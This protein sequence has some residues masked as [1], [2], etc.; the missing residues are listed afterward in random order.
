[1]AA[2]HAGAAPSTTQWLQLLRAHDEGM[3]EIVR[4]LRA[5]YKALT[6]VDMGAIDLTSDTTTL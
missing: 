3:Q 6:G 5:M 2:F 4:R 1:M